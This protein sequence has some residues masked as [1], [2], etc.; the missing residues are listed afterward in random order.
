MLRVRIPKE[1]SD[2]GADS[3]ILGVSFSTHWMSSCRCWLANRAA[4]T[5]LAFPLGLDEGAAI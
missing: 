3:Q 4:G 2:E 5:E 1:V